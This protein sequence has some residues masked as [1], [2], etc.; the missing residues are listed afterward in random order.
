MN[1][2]RTHFVRSGANVRDVDWASWTGV[3]GFD[4]MG[5]WQDGMDG[6]D[7]NGLHRSGDGRFCVGSADDGLVRLFNSPSVIDRAPHHA[8][9]G[10]SSHVQNVRFLADDLRVVSAGGRDGSMMQWTTHG[11]TKPSSSKALKK[12]VESGRK[13]AE[14]DKPTPPGIAR[15][16]E[17]VSLDQLQERDKV[18]RAQLKEKDV[19]IQKLR[20]KIKQ[21]KLP[22]TKE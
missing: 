10:H 19:Q 6:T 12:V 13:H 15:E 22:A 21:Q 7:Y 16:R 11:V 20:Q 17:A 14:L 5:V 18:N 9:R 8:H 4:V 3:L 1:K 2:E